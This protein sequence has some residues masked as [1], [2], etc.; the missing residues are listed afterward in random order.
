MGEKAVI[1]FDRDIATTAKC[2]CG[3]HK[4]LFTPVHKLKGNMLT[5]PKCGEQMSFDSVHSIKGD[6]DYLDKTPFEIGIP[7]LH[8]IGGRIGMNT[9]YY[10]FSADE[11]EVF[12]NL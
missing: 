8:I 6:E 7:L 5:C 3:E 1:D 10:E 4:E 12:E 11:A 9:T 2:A